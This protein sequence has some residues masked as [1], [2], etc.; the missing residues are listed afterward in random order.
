[1]KGRR[2]I[3]LGFARD[4]TE[5]AEALD[6]ALHLL[7]TGINLCLILWRECGHHVFKGACHGI[8]PEV[9]F[10]QGDR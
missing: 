6:L 7:K 4:L 5:G 9:M 10:V 8:I 1:M 3:R 2:D